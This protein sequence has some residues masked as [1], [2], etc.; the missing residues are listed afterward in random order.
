MRVADGETQE[1]ATYV[2][3]AYRETEKTVPAAGDSQ[4]LR[5]T[6]LQVDSLKQRNISDV[7]E[8]FKPPSPEP[9]SLSDDMM[10][11][12]DRKSKTLRSED[13]SD[14]DFGKMESGKESIDRDDASISEE[15]LPI[16]TTDEA[17]DSADEEPPLQLDTV[18]GAS[19]RKEKLEPPKSNKTTGKL[20]LDFSINSIRKCIKLLLFYFVVLR[21]SSLVLS[22]ENSQSNQLLVL[23]RW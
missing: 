8:V 22:F 4:G 18:D 20:I 10:E 16:Q 11:K 1:T 12:F 9:K 15:G 21:R 14:Y 17:A 3:E 7:S 13:I 6:P 23:F 19:P 5:K 2:N